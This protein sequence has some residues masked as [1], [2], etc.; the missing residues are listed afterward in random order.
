MK[1]SAKLLTLAAAIVAMSCCVIST[2]AQQSQV[3]PNVTVK[4]NEWTNSCTRTGYDFGSYA[5]SATD[6]ELTAQDG[7]IDC[8]LLK[9]VS[10][11]VQ[12]HMD[13]TL[14]N[15]S[16]TIS[17]TQFTF[18]ATAWNTNGSLAQDTAH[19][20]QTATDTLVVYEKGQYNIWQLTGIVVT[21]DGVIPWGTPSWT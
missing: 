5:V 6:T 3:N 7:T 17:W 1:K 16:S 12:I 19:S 11:N 15:G 18:V 13:E 20:S 4:I 14:S 8:T 9:S 10:W 21:I 2:Y